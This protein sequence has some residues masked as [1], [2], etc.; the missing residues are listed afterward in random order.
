MRWSP[1]SLSLCLACAAPSA[2][3]PPAQQAIDIPAHTQAMIDAYRNV[4]ATRAASSPIAVAQCPSEASPLQR[5]EAYLRAVDGCV[6]PS[7]PVTPPL[8]LAKRAQWPALYATLDAQ[9]AGVERCIRTGYTYFD[10]QGALTT[11][12]ELAADGAVKAVRT[13]RDDA[14]TPD[15][16]CC[17][18]RELRQLK[19]PA[20]GRPLAIERVD[21]FDAAAL[22]DR[23]GGS[24][25]SE[26]IRAVAAAHNMELR[27]CYDGAVRD[28]LSHGGSVTLRFVIAPTGEVSRAT[29]LEDSI[30]SPTAACCFVEKVHGWRFPQPQ[31]GGPV[32]VTYPF[33]VQLGS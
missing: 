13:E 33:V 23:Y 10:L 29:V 12:L 3:T 18:R 8:D 26:D 21:T 6:E 28:G 1:L 11:R 24:L 15:V 32:F 27:N 20:P 9:L 25:P 22:K 14:S 4:Q 7:E 19:L 5:R 31:R 16:A 2:Q 17:V 30:G